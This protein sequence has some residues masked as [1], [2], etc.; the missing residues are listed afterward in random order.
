LLGAEAA[1]RPSNP[2]MWD[3]ITAYVITPV[4]GLSALDAR[5]PDL[6]ATLVQRLERV[7]TSRLTAFGPSPRPQTAPPPH[8]GAAIDINR[9]RRG[10]AGR[11]V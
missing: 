11:D 9:A 5:R 2:K 3:V 4:N 6:L 1:E 7:R 10:L 8:P